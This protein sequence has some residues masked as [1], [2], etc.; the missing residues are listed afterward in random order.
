MKKCSSWEEQF[1]ILLIKP[2]EKES[3]LK[4]LFI[5]AI[6]LFFLLLLKETSPSTFQ[7]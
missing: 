7:S 2:C 1:N 5:S 6:I 4:F 3:E